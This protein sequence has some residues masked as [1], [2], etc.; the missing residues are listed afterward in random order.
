VPLGCARSREVVA[1]CAW[2]LI[3]FCW[4]KVDMAPATGTALLVL[5]IFVLPGFVA[6]LIGERTHVV[7][8]D[9]SPFELLLVATYYSV[10]CWGILA[11]ASWPFGL[12]RADL[13]RWYREESL[14][15]IAGL[16]LLA[17]L[18]IPAIVA[19]VA[20][21]WMRSKEWRP[22]VL[23]WLQIHEGHSVPTA[24]DELFRRRKP[25]LVRAVLTDGRIIGGYYGS[26]SFPGYGE[27]SQDLLLQRRWTL[28]TDYWFLERDE[29][30]L[31]LWLS[32][33]SIVSLELYDPPNA[34]T[35]KV[36]Q[37]PAQEGER[38]RA[39]AEGQRTNQPAG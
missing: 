11:L 22:K 16:G 15:R 23:T 28:D 25:A 19:T 6:L 33:G 5:V 4:Y 20:R 31:G 17:I 12:T 29:A 24:W 2:S 35:P 13:V 34:E 7:R 8:R 27:E 26:T 39:A 1:T 10:I 30:S 3:R 38:P 18:V 37:L 36:A 9:R 14:G 21:L 32:A